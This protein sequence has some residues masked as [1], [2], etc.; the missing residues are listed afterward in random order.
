MN[1]EDGRPKSK[2]KEQKKGSFRTKLRVREK[3][4]KNESFTQD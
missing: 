1:L 4:K 2:H 3:K